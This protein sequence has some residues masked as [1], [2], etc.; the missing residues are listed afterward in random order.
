MIELVDGVEII[1]EQ[2][3]Y[4]YEQLFSSDPAKIKYCPGPYKV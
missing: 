3:Y 2:R 1:Y 4:C